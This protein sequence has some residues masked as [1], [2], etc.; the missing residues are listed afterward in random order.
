MAGIVA[1]IRLS[2]VLGEVETPLPPVASHTTAPLAATTNYPLF[3][4]GVFLVWVAALAEMRACV[5]HARATSRVIIADTMPTQPIHDTEMPTA[6]SGSE[7]DG[8]SPSRVPMAPWGMPG[9]RGTYTRN[10]GR[11]DW[12][13]T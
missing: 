2:P 13:G 6:S 3:L 1:R 12:R 11:Q 7:L 8:H 4:L 10:R 5:P 9:A